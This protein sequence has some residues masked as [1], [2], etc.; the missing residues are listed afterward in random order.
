MH[1]LDELI[2]RLWNHYSGVNPQA[3]K[4]HALL[5]S[6]GERIC[7]DH[8]AFRTF[9]IPKVG[10]DAL[11]N[12]FLDFGYKEEGSYVFEA[13]KLD[14]KHYRHSDEKYPLIFISELKIS[15]SFFHRIGNRTQICKFLWISA[16]HKGFAKC[17]NIF[18]MNGLSIFVRECFNKCGFGFTIRSIPLKH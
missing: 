17:P 14:A 4:I 18:H 1:T 16:C 5:E 11:A 2:E 9:N 13:K 15:Y 6:R 12:T 10:I 8:I 3:S 7:N